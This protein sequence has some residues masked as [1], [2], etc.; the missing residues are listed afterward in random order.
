MEEN[1][2]VSRPKAWRYNPVRFFEKLFAV[3]PYTFTSF[4]DISTRSSN[5]HSSLSR[6][7]S[8]VEHYIICDNGL[9]TTVANKNGGI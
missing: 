5:P 1:Q 2:C 7:L 4:G 3:P 6:H 9:E 8:I